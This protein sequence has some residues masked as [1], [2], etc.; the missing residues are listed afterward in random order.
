MEATGTDWCLDGKMPTRDEFLDLLQAKPELGMSGLTADEVGRALKKFRSQCDY[1]R[2]QKRAEAAAE[3][4]RRCN[5]TALLDKLAEDTLKAK[6]WYTKK[7]H[8]RVVEL[9]KKRIKTNAAIKKTGQQAQ[10]GSTDTLPDW[11]A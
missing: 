2:I 7:A 3:D 8:T 1:I 10:E 9:Q 6:G 5:D 11:C 4:I